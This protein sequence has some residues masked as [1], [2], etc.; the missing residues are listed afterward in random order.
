MSAPK[1]FVFGNV[2][3]QLQPAFSKLAAL[4]SKNNFSFAIVVGNLFGPADDDAVSDLISGKIEVPVTTYFT[5]GTHPLPERIVEKVT[6]D[7]GEICPNLHYIN[8]RSVTKTSEGVRIVT[9]AGI[10]DTE[11]V[12][13]QSQEQH[14]PFHTADDAKALRGASSADILLTTMWPSSIWNASPMALPFDRASVVTSD[15]I[16]DLCATL[17]PRYH[18]CPSPDAFVYEREPFFHPPKDPSSDPEVTRFISLAP[19]GNTQ[20]AKAMYAFSLTS[21]PGPLPQ[22][23]TV[24][25]F[26]SRG[27][28]AKKRSAPE[29]EGFSRFSNGH[30][31]D[32]RHNRRRKGNRG[33]RLPLPGPDQCFFCLA[34]ENAENHMV[35]SIGDDTYLATAKG[36]LT[37]SDTF[38]EHGLDC[39]SH[40]IIVPQEHVPSISRAAMGQEGADRA[41][42]EMSRFREALQ[43]TVSKKSKHKLGGVT[44]EINRSTNIHAHWQFMPVPADLITKGLVEAAFKVEA[45]N[46]RLPGLVF[47]DFGISDE[48]PGDYVRVWIWYEDEGEGHEDGGKIVSKCLLMR[49]DEN[50][51]FDLQYPRKV[52][53]KLLGLEK[54]VIWQECTQTTEEEAQDTTKFRETFQ[55]WDFTLMG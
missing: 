32:H 54:R 40:M 1:I 13:G 42:A 55:E 38:H 48:V 33:Q 53:A 30:H 29:E 2:N 14:L 52:M 50:V 27:N 7:D 39:P 49:F 41:F 8:K 22:G 9:L 5:V 23:S 21:S 20:K 44:W 51:R 25:P 26:L 10:L 15:D 16:A 17:K 36:P 11:I 45:E 31:D 34:S 6:N 24:S 35:C 4:H 18:F 43:A 46:L 28:L 3:G 19:F 12:G 47:K 37:T